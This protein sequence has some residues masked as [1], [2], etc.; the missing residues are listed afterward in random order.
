MRSKKLI[1]SIIVAVLVSATFNTLVGTNS[2]GAANPNCTAADGD[3]IV[4]FNRNANVRSEIKS[5]PGKAVGAK[6]IY[7]SVLNGFAA[8]LSAEQVCAFEKRPNIESIEPDQKIEADLSTQSVGTS[9]WGLDRI[10][11]TA[12]I[13]DLKYSYTSNGS[14]A[15]AFIVDTGINS[16]HNEFGNRID[17]GFWTIGTSAEDCNGHGTHVAGTIGG[18]SSGVAKSVRLTP[19]RVL[20]CNGSG[21][22]SGV[23]AGLNWIASQPSTKAVVNMSLGGG[24]STALDSAVSNLTR[25]GFVVVVA[26]GNSKRD[27]CNFSP[28]R[29]ASAITVAASDINDQFASFS[30]YGKCVDIIA[31]GVNITSAWIGSSS[32]TN[33]ISGTSMAS[34]HVAGVVAR[35]L[36][37]NLLPAINGMSSSNTVKNVPRGTSNLLLYLD[38]NK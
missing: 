7:D 25:L 11:T 14:G 37:A 29:V 30:N 8:T 24:A 26:A 27:A 17:P 15:K 36:G 16:G 2:A 38:P 23:I 20:D 1:S 31:P 21:S 3:Y 34:P 35:L 9:L 13:L 19:V 10:D 22:N 6:F 5:A 28:A 18:T 32:S 33:S 4:V 12:R